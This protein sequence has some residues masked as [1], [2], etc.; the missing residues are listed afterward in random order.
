MENRT[1]EQQIQDLNQKLDFVIQYIQQQEKR[2]RQ[3]DELKEDLTVIGKDVFQ[4]AVNELDEVSSH[5]EMEDLLHLLK[6][7][8]RNIRNLNRLFDFLESSMQFIDD[9]TPLAND[10]FKSLL[11]ELDRMEKK[12]YFE[13]F[14][15]TLGIFDEIVTSF[16]VEDVRA[17]RKNIVPILNTVRMLTQP[18][19]LEVVTNAMN[20]FQ[21]LSEKV[22]EE[23]T[24]RMILKELRKPKTRQSLYFAIHVLQKLTDFTPPKNENKQKEV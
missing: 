24:Y 12:G 8:M 11:E 22:E 5:F 6:R 3:W 14:R 2:N 10:A 15:E 16:T 4:A 18:E 23:V 17:L 9:A 20:F 13:F 21:S 7:I 19:I 1:L